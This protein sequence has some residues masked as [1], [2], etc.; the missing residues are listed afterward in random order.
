MHQSM[1]HL[2]SLVFATGNQ[3]K[4]DEINHVLGNRVKLQSLLDLGFN[5]EIPEE[6]YTLEGNAA[7]KALF[8]YRK[9]GMDCFADDT[10][11]EIEALNGEPGVF[12][13]RYAGKNCSFEDNMNK[14]LQKMIGKNNRN[15][16]FRTV[17]ALV[18]NG[19]LRYF[20]GEVQGTIIR[21]KRGTAGFGYDPIFRP[22]G[23]SQTFAEMSLAD[24]N[25]ISHRARAINQLLQYFSREQS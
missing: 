11:L 23:F 20:K 16:R 25:L 1:N 17:I 21:E 8:I 13:A 19:Q 7:Q 2:P 9:F 12:S 18:E 15:A 4:F 3:H 6:M 5:G 10:G 22:E 14:V 24:K